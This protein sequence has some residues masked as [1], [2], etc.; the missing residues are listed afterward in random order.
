MP[1]DYSGLV[2]IA[3]DQLAEFGQA[4]TVE[5]YTSSTG[6]VDGNVTPNYGSPVS[7]NAVV[8]LLSSEER[9]TLSLDDRARRLLLDAKPLTAASINLSTR[10]RLTVGGV[11]V[12]VVG[13]EAVSPAGTPVLY[14]VVGRV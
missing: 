7:T 6:D 12:E 1:F 5:S 13:V 14:K 3:S 2:D 9:A 11:V 4:A 10:D 8:T